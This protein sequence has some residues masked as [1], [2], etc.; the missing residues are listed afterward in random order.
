M[1]MALKIPENGCKHCSIYTY[2]GFPAGYIQAWHISFLKES[3]ENQE[4]PKHDAH[5]A[6]QSTAGVFFPLLPESLPV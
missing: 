2:L 3:L 6:F 5:V 1:L 4:T